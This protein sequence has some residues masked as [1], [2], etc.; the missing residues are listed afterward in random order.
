MTGFIYATEVDIF[1][2][3]HMLLELIFCFFQDSS[4][5]Y[6]LVAGGLLVPVDITR[7]VV[8]ASALTWFIRYISLLKFT[9]P[10]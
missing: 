8:N 3:M 10:K 7:P 5:F 2:R 9:V 4:N 1:F 6:L